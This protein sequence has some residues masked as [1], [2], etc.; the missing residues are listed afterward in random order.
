[1]YRDNVCQKNSCGTGNPMATKEDHIRHIVL[2]NSMIKTL[3]KP[4]LAPAFVTRMEEML[5]TIP[6]AVVGLRNFG[7]RQVL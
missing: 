2:C 1:M 7:Q 5:W 3:Q 4:H 6:P